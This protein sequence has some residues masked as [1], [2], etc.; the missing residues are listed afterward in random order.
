MATPESFEPSSPECDYLEIVLDSP[1]YPDNLKDICSLLETAQSQ[2]NPTQPSGAPAAPLVPCNPDVPPAPVTLSNITSPA[3]V[4]ST[5]QG[6]HQPWQPSPVHQSHGGY[7]S[8]TSIP[9]L[10]TSSSPTGYASVTSIPGLTTSS[11]PTGSVVSSPQGYPIQDSSPLLANTGLQPCVVASTAVQPSVGWSPTT[12]PSNPQLIIITP[13][14]AVSQSNASPAG[15]SNPSYTTSTPSP[16]VAT[17]WNTPTTAGTLSAPSQPTTS[18]DPV[19][20][21]SP[22][23]VTPVSQSPLQQPSNTAV[24]STLP[25]K[26]A[27]LQQITSNPMFTSLQSVLKTECQSQSAVPTALMTSL[28]HTLPAAPLSVRVGHLHLQFQTLRSQHP[29]NIPALEGFYMEQAARIEDQRFSTLQH[30]QH[31]PWLMASI[32]NYY[33]IQHHTL[34]TRIENS[35]AL[36][37]TPTL[38]ILA[39]T[40]KSSPKVKATN[41]NQHLSNAME[42]SATSELPPKTLTPTLPATPRAP[43]TQV[44]RKCSTLNPVAVRIMSNWYERNSEHPYPSYAAAEVMGKAGNI[45]VEQVKKWFAN[46]RRRQGDTKSIDEIARRRKRVRSDSSESILLTGAKRQRE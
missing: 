16:Q 38:S 18:S 15:P 22:I 25:W 45:T 44:F 5:L 30:T 27:P 13:T 14:V 12:L 42:G 39:S 32:N 35:L 28:G 6:L 7:A 29:A 24:A 3:E 8:P 17:T 9:G 33:D 46:R 11:S 2:P 10:T 4:P 41:Y 43:P 37:H 34:I 20:T 23:M 1:E 40:P 26:N 19:V 36:L 31:T 21:R